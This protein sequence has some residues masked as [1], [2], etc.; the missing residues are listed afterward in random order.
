MGLSPSDTRI[1]RLSLSKIY[2]RFGA[3][4][5]S[6][7]FDPG[8]L[9]LFYNDTVQ[10]DGTCTLASTVFHFHEIAPL[11]QISETHLSEAIFLP[12]QAYQKKTGITLSGHPLAIQLKNCHAVESIGAALQ[13][14]ARSLGE[15]Q[16]GDRII[17][18]IEGTV[19]VLCRLLATPARGDAIG[20][21]RQKAL[22]GIYVSLILVLQGFQPAEAIQTGL[23]VLIVVCPFFK[24]SLTY[25]CDI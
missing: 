3:H 10:C 11:R 18:S 15:F 13:D 8:N 5:D 14:Q 2:A 22:M 9:L 25:R 6:V 7:R 12:L 21:V 16:G 23:A 1:S 4:S 19:S 20:L 24:F 17:E